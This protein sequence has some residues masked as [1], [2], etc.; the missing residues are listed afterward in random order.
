MI[1]IEKLSY[2]GEVSICKVCYYLL[3]LAAGP[4]SPI[5][6][7]LL[8]YFLLNY[9]HLLRSTSVISGYRLLCG[10]NA[11]RCSSNSTAK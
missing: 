3:V 10:S 4:F 2:E 1:G 5:V 7:T 9:G 6:N 8:S 11:G